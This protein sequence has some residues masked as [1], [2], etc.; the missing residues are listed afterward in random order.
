M[1]RSAL[2]RSASISASAGAKHARNLAPRAW[3]ETRGAKSA[4]KREGNAAGQ[5]PA[6][7]SPPRA[8]SLLKRPARAVLPRRFSEPPA[9]GRSRSRMRV[10]HGP[11]P[12]PTPCPSD[13]C[14][15]QRNSGAITSVTV[16]SSLMST[17]KLGPAVSLKGSPSVSPTT[18]ALCASV[19][20]PP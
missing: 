7:R 20:L 18:A 19:P 6:E 10:R 4:W 8:S 3:P 17:C 9:A 14:R 1:L 5:P 15:P 16:P 12:A 13:G 11:Q 2:P